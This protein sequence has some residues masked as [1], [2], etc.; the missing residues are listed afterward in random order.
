MQEKTNLTL[1]QKLFLGII[2]A[3]LVVCLFIP[4]A[5]VLGKVLWTWA[6]SI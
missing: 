2:T 5:I 3:L 1:G 6:L 4:L